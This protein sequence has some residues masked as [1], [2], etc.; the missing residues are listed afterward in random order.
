[1]SARRSVIL[2]G[3]HRHP[4]RFR[5]EPAFP[6]DAFLLWFPRADAAF[7]LPPAPATSSP[8]IFPVLWLPPPPDNLFLFPPPAA[9][10]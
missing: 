4:V 9:P 7:L 2:Q 3:M 6:P 10:P 5:S 1:M 8:D